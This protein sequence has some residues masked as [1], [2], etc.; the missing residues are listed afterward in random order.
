MMQVDLCTTLE[1]KLVNKIVCDGEW[2][3]FMEDDEVEHGGDGGNKGVPVPP[4]P[5]V[6]AQTNVKQ[7][8]CF[9]EGNL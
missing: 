2:L 9:Y 5:F 8:Y 6:H 1:F 3:C 4:L 7:C